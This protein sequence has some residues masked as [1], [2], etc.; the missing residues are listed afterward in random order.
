MGGSEATA[1]PGYTG[2]PA[3]STRVPVSSRLLIE[4]RAAWRLL[5]L[6]A[7]L[8]RGL[9]MVRWRFPHWDEARRRAVKLAWS[10][11]LLCCLGVRQD[12]ARAGL[13][14]ACLIVSNHVSWLDIFVINAMT[15]TH[16]VCKD[17]VRHWP[18]IGWLVAQSGT[19]FIERGSRA[20]AARTAQTLVATLGRGERVVVFPE[21]TTTDGHAL[22]PFKSALFQSA[23]DAGVP[24]A[25][26]ALRYLDRDGHPS[27]APA[28]DGDITFW[29]CLRNI[30]RAEGLCVEVSL[31]PLLP[32]GLERRELA[33]T[34]WQRIADGLGMAHSLPRRNQS[35]PLGEEA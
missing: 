11:R 24:V 1:A 14:P 15:E 32:T 25:P 13:P 19:V 3:V 4:C 35:Q 31:L 28:Y 9:Y 27:R 21:G 20:A 6:A 7:H 2:R 16:F 18:V 12:G 23:V 34:S 10:R 26:A 8:A 17:E 33:E 5:R 22:L 29:E 30:A